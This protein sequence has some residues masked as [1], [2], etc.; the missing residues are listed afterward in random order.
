MARQAKFKQRNPKGCM[1]CGDLKVGRGIQTH[2]LKIHDI[3]YETYKKCFESG[4]VLL[5]TLVDTGHVQ[6]G[7]LNPRKVI[8]HVFVRRFVVRERN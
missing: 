4:E 2:V 1:L 6:T 5:N 7:R 8:I 3:S